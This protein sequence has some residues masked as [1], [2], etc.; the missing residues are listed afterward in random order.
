M[1]PALRLDLRLLAW[2][3]RALP[4]ALLASVLLHAAA[5]AQAGAAV[6]GSTFRADTTNVCIA[7]SESR[8]G[9]AAVKR[10]AA[11]IPLDPV[12][13]LIEPLAG[14]ARLGP[15]APAP[16]ATSALPSRSPRRVAH[17]LGARAPPSV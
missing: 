6:G 17:G 5:P 9:L 2:L 8:I 4:L 13:C 14:T 3:G 15:A 11:P 16:V 12:A 7:P 10:T 1:H